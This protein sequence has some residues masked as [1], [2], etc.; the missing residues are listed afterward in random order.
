MASSEPGFHARSAARFRAARPCRPAA[1]SPLTSAIALWYR[2]TC[3]H[4][5]PPT[6]RI[7]TIK[8]AGTTSLHGRPLFAV[9]DLRSSSIPW[10]SINTA[11]PGL[12]LRSLVDR[13]RPNGLAP[14]ARFSC[15]RCF[16]VLS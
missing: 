11:S 1:I 14:L 5:Q 2:R 7:A 15:S 6:E 4:L 13:R 10:I 9:A 12:D 8:T 3:H 16:A